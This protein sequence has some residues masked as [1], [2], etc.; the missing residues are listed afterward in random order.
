MLKFQIGNCQTGATVSISNVELK[1]KNLIH[2]YLA[3]LQ[4]IIDYPLCLRLKTLIIIVLLVLVKLLVQHFGIGLFRPQS[5]T[6]VNI[7]SL[8]IVLPDLTW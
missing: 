3:M 6:H 7:L 4:Y 2:V 8:G 1:I 5:C